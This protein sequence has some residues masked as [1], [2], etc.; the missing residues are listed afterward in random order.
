LYTADLHQRLTEDLCS[1]YVSEYLFPY[2][3]H[4]KKQSGDS[5]NTSQKIGIEIEMIPF[6]LGNSHNNYSPPRANQI[7]VSSIIKNLGNQCAWT[8]EKEV[9]SQG[10]ELL[11]KCVTN[12]GDNLSFEP[13]GQLEFSSIPHS[14]F[15]K[16]MKETLHIQS[17]IDH[18]LSDQNIALLQTGL[19]PWNS[20]E[21]VGLQVPKKRYIAMDHYFNEINTYGQQM[22]RQTATIQVCLDYGGTPQTAVQR[23]IISQLLSPV[24]TSI[25]SFSAFFNNSY[26]GI[27]GYRSQVWRNLD[28]SRTG[29]TNL[30]SLL[31]A[32]SS[33]QTCVNAYLE[34]ILNAKVTFIEDHNYY[35]PLNPITFREWIKNGVKGTYPTLKDFLS[36]LSLL[37]PEVRPRGFLEIRSPDSGLRAWQFVSAAFLAGILY[38][39][40]TTDEVGKLLSKQV[41]Q[42]NYLL[43]QSELGLKEEPIKS[44]AQQIFQLAINGYK[45]L[46]E[47]LYDSEAEKNLWM[48]FEKFVSRGQTP[49]DVLLKIVQ[50][51]GRNKVFWED[52]LN[53][54]KWYLQN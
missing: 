49:S 37:F 50:E 41:E 18:A 40:K 34:F 45:K 35:V 29:L 54:E 7:E 32:N 38:D 10:R 26:S 53:L 25:F 31:L 33:I 14:D 4:N 21:E 15:S 47:P 51:S 9:T 6:K 43:K 23:Y 13:G 11:L 44:L 8:W 48:Y 36:H 12:N 42:S 46:P 52:Y 1:D 5:D 17:L 28:N 22:M 30:D 16:L 3:S 19:D 20:T 2:N 27:P 39:S 24:T